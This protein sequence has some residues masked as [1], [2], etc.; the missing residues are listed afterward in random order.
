VVHADDVVEVTERT[1]RGGAFDDAIF[2]RNAFQVG[3]PEFTWLPSQPSNKKKS[4]VELAYDAHVA[5]EPLMPVL[6]AALVY[7]RGASPP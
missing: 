5:G 1:V 4:D 3:T 2:Q 6:E 7:L